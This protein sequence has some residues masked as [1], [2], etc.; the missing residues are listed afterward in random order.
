MSNIPKPEFPRPQ[1]QRDTWMNLNGSWDFQLFSTDEAQQE[2]AFRQNRVYQRKI[3]VPFTWTCPLSGVEEKE[4]GTGWYSRIVQ[5]SSANRIFL[6]FGAVD[7]DCEVYINGKLAGTHQGGYTYFEFD[8]TEL[9]QPGENLIEVRAQ[10]DRL[11]SQ[12]YGKQGYGEIQGIWQTVWLEER[13]EFYIESFRFTTK[14]TG[15][16]GLSAK[17]QAPDGTTLT[18]EFGGISATGIA[19]N[20]Q[21]EMAFQL[22]NPRLWSLEDPYLYEGTLKLDGD[23][24]HTYFGVREIGTA[25]FD[26][27]NYPWITLNGKPVYINGTLDQAFNPQGYFTYPDEESV[28]Q[29]AASVKRLGLNMARIHIKAE[30][31]RKLYWMDKLGV[32]VMADV[33]CFWG[34]PNQAAQDGYERDWPRILSRDINHPCIFAWVMFNET[35][36]L[37]TH[38]EDKKVYLPETQA[39]VESVYHRAKAFDPTRLVED[40][41]PCNNDHTV[42]D[43]NT[44]HFYLNGYEQVRDHIR[45]RVEQCYPGSADNCI[46]GYRQM[47]APLMNSECGMVWGVDD[48]AGDSDLAWQYHY[49]LNEYRLHDKICGFIFTELNDVVNEFNGYYRIDNTDKE[50]GYGYFCRG[51]TLKDLHAKCF[52][53]TDC[54]PCRTVCGGE[55]V[56]V[57]LFLSNFEAPQSVGQK[58]CWELWHEDASGRITDS[59]GEVQLPAYGYGSL[60]LAP[61][62]LSMPQANAVAVLSLYLTDGQGKILGRNFTTFDVRASL[63][64]NVL[65]IP[66][67]Q[68]T[69]RRFNPVWQAIGGEKLCLGGAGEVEYE[70]QLPSHGMLSEVTVSLEASAKRVL[71]KDCGSIGDAEPDLGF[72]RGYLVDRGSFANSYFMTDESRFPSQAEVLINGEKVAVLTLENDWADARGVLSWQAQPNHRKLDEVGSFGEKKQIKIP[73]RLLNAI[74]KK[75]GFTLTLKVKEQGGLALYGRHAGRYPLG[76]Q[77]S[78]N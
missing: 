6:C 76:I 2:E 1:C 63:P 14:I 15:E 35:W 31:P 41:S 7:H 69:V 19:Q 64:D 74:E 55:K 70:I 12:L 28:Q 21:V 52:V 57:P 75:G 20:G 42:T 78:W 68:G 36:G 39:W 30:E 45:A 16:I 10:D 38:V 65:E 58:I 33:P 3:T 18:A 25:S 50:F 44:W 53:A 47:G 40:N 26:G 60:E 37:F 56:T 17:V 67:S 29:V 54:P 5:F 48:S 32:L 77:V 62:Q 61:I 46:A 23:V 51:M 43:L 49:M 8:V 73:G 4:A 34:E 71:T 22:Q 59:T 9:W 66:V 11:E 13:S 24:I 27:K 72:M